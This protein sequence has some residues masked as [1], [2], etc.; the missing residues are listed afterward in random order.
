MYKFITSALHEYVMTVGV[1]LFR[2]QWLDED[3][4]P[5]ESH[6]YDLNQATQW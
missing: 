6:L 4:V 1:K 3:S 5:Y 2:D